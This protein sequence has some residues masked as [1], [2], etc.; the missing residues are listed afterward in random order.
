MSAVIPF[1]ARLIAVWYDLAISFPPIQSHLDPN[2]LVF[3]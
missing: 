1:T 2:F 3:L